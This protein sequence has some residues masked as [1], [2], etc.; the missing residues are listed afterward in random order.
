MDRIIL[1]SLLIMG[2]DASCVSKGA[3]V[4]VEGRGPKGV[5]FA[6]V[7]SGMGGGILGVIETADMPNCSKTCGRLPTCTAYSYAKSTLE[8]SLYAYSAD[9]KIMLGEPFGDVSTYAMFRSKDVARPTLTVDSEELAAYL[10]RN[11]DR[12]VHVADQCRN[13]AIELFKT[14]SPY[15]LHPSSPSTPALTALESPPP[16]FSATERTAL[17]ATPQLSPYNS[18][19]NADS[20]SHSSP[21]VSADN[22]ATTVPVFERA[23]PSAGTVPTGTTPHHPTLPNF[24]EAEEKNSKA[25]VI[26]RLT[27]LED[28]PDK[29]SS[30]TLSPT[31]VGSEPSTGSTVLSSTKIVNSEGKN[32]TVGVSVSLPSSSSVSPVTTSSSTSSYMSNDSRSVP[33]DTESRSTNGETSVRS[34]TIGGGIG[35]CFDVFRWTNGEP[36]AQPFYLRSIE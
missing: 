34:S 33:E 8:C 11:V 17:P 2:I 32:A 23:T 16:T 19:E 28:N 5:G 4:K 35:A 30:V 13:P 9:A 27:R 1:L 26:S 24:T 20:I 22:L 25:T 14:S 10:R 6:R 29:Y 7:E 12:E 21:G 15:P 31:V 18:T 36:I 3:A